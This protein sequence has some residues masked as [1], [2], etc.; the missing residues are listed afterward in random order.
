MPRSRQ[1]LARAILSSSSSPAYR[2]VRARVL[3]LLRMTPE[4]D[5]RLSGRACARCGATEGLH[6]GGYAYT[7]LFSR[8]YGEVTSSP[9]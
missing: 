8:S 3:D 4:Q 6:E 7:A 2:D 9:L 1:S 5:R